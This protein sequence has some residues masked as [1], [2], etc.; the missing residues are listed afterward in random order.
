VIGV[1]FEIAQ[2]QERLRPEKSEVDRLWSNNA[3][4]ARILR[5]RPIYGGKAG[6]RRGLSET[7][8]WFRDPVNR[9]LYKA[10]IYNR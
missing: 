1:S 8:E 6:L 2:E 7:V 4:A 10:T 9:D 3:K 5:W